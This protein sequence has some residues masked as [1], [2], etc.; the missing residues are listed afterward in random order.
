MQLEAGKWVEKRRYTIGRVMIDL[1]SFR[2]KSPDSK[3]LP[4]CAINNIKAEDIL[5]DALLF[6][7]HRVLGFSFSTKS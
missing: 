1:A 3:L 4:L 6:C 2:A 7:S 5:E